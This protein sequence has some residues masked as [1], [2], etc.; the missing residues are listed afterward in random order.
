MKP[1]IQPLLSWKGACIFFGD[2][3]QDF[4]GFWDAGLGIRGLP[5][6]NPPA[7][8]T[9]CEPYDNYRRLVRNLFS[10]SIIV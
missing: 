10:I 2:L 1:V 8:R 7:M 6:R 4:I 9:L 5:Y 3:G